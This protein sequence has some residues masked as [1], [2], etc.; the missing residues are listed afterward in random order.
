MHQHKATSNRPPIGKDR[1][2]ADDSLTRRSGVYEI[3]NTANGK[4]YVGSAVEFRQRHNEHRS[5][6]RRGKHHSRPFQNAW[7]KYGE[8]AFYF[9]V[10]LVC[11]PENLVLYEQRALDAL[12]PDYNVC[13]VAGSTLGKTHSPETRAK[14]AA[15]A[16]GRKRPAMSAEHRAAL[17]AAM[18]LRK[19]I[20]AEHM[21]ALQRGRMNKVVTDAQRKAVGDAL[22]RAYA[23]GM[24]SRV[25]TDAAKKN[26]SKAFS[27]LNADEIR[28]LKRLHAAGVTGVSLSRRFNIATSSV[29]QIVRGLRYRWVE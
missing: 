29:S 10:L 5:M 21:A 2:M 27:K 23:S 26:M 8:A 1:Q 6:L 7:N 15:K 19:P 22:R 28:E 17:S 3:L 24:R 16:S 18:K 4:R 12:R 14:I 9:R 13:L 20:S 25:K 11:A